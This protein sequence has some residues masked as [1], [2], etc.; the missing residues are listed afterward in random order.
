[1]WRVSYSLQLGNVFV[2]SVL[3]LTMFRTEPIEFLVLR[4]E[5]KGIESAAY[6]EAVRVVQVKH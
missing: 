6:K 3:W 4:A 2:T 5:N 1:M